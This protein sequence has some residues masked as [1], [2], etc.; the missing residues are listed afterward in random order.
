MGIGVVHANMNDPE[1]RLLLCAM[2][3]E[4]STYRGD[5]EGYKTQ[6]SQLSEELPNNSLTTIPGPTT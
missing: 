1:M 6:A 2:W 4:G 3:V 5:L